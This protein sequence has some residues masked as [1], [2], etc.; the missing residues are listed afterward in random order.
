MNQTQTVKALGLTSNKDNNS[1]AGQLCAIAKLIAEI[2]TEQGFFATS[3]EIR[4]VKSLMENHKER[5]A[6]LKL[7]QRCDA[8]KKMN[9]L[10]QFESMH[11]ITFG[12]IGKSKYTFDVPTG[13]DF[14]NYVLSLCEIATKQLEISK[15]LPVATFLFNAEIAAKIQ[16]AKAYMSNDYLTPNMCNVMLHIKGDKT[17]VVATDAHRVYVSAEIDNSYHNSSDDYKI[18]LPLD[19]VKSLPKKS[20]D[21][22]MVEIFAGGTLKFTDCGTIN[23]ITGKIF[24]E[25]FPKNWMWLFPDYEAVLPT[26]FENRM[27]VD[28]EGLLQNLKITMGAANKVTN[29]VKLHLNGSIEMSASDVDYGHQQHN[30][31]PYLSSNVPDME[32][33]FNGRLL[34]EILKGFNAKEIVFSP[35]SPTR[36]AKFTDGTDSAYL[37]P[38]MIM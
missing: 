2:K 9:I 6:K 17:K 30:K 12:I 23:G 1:F 8:E 19:V 29:Q 31:M 4:D 5:I 20:T 26:N 35:E 37:M 24:A 3:G 36:V 10:R 27:E 38:L 16:S 32:L 11:Q 13:N 28:R 33:A 14:Y 21:I 18:L 15:L 34:S 7:Y 22:L 25:Q